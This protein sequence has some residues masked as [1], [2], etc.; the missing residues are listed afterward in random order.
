MEATRWRPAL[1]PERHLYG[2]ISS[3]A[4]VQRQSGSPNPIASA[5]YGYSGRYQLWHRGEYRL[6]PFVRWETYN[7]GSSYQGTSGPQIPSGEVP[8]GTP[9][10]YG[11]WPIN[12]DRV[13]TVGANFY[14]GPHVVLKSDYQWFEENTSFNRW[15]LGLGVAF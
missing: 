6:N 10:E 13:W 11:L 5:F 3:T 2:A 15:D 8:L 7:M 9:G 4:S 14:L 1:G 12:H